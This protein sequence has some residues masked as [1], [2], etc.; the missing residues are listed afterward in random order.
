MNKSDKVNIYTNPCFIP[1]PSWN[2]CPPPPLPIALPIAL[3][4]SSKIQK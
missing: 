3:P 4:T 1:L 2:S